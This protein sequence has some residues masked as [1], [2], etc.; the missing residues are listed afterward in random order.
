MKNLLFIATVLVG[1]SACNMA[2]DADYKGMASDMCGCFNDATAGLSDE[3]RKA[4]EDAGQNDTD[5][6]A[7]LMEYAQENPMQAMQD[8]Q[9]LSSLGEAD[10]MACISDLEKKYDDVYTTDSEKEVQDKLMEVMKDMKE[11]KLTYA[12]V[13]AGLAMQ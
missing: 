5:M 10:V 3:G 9:V 11:C 7:A 2:D 4:I 13:K 8:G 12:F 1:L 6:Q